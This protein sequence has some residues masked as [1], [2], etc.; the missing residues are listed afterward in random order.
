MS[1]E[2]ANGSGAGAIFQE[3]RSGVS[4][5]G[6]LSFVDKYLPLPNRATLLSHDFLQPPRSGCF[7]CAIHPCR[8]RQTITSC[9]VYYGTNA[10]PGHQW[11]SLGP[12][13]PL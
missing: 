5:A 7:H 8:Q 2:S 10:P 6:E 4:G 11:S 13:L 1:G 9:G 12:I 3:R